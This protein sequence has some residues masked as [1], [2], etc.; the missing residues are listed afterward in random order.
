M[1]C[2]PWTLALIG[3]GVVTL[4][5]VTQAEEK[6]SSVL[7]SL[8]ATTLSGYVDTSAQWNLGTG[9]K[10]VPNYAWGGSARLTVSI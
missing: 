9:N 5:A 8:T 7:T 6:P 3:A 10:N 4:P 1:K 2:K